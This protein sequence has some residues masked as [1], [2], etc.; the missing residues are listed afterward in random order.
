M[1]AVNELLTSGLCDRFP[2]LN[3]VL[4]ESG[5]G[6]LR[7]SIES[8]DWHWIATGRRARF[9]DRSLPSESFYRQVYATFSYERESVLHALPDLQ[10][11]VMFSTDFPHP[12]S[13]APG[14]CCPTSES[15]VE[16]I[17]RFDEV[18]FELAEKALHQNAARVYHLAV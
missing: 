9:T 17:E 12:A 15:P 11:N 14:P 8:L 13:L 5:A 1:R 3:F 18:P 7:H 4:V 16:V 6:W 2:E 10:D